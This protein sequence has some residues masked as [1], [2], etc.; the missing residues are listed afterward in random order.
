MG[1][2][3]LYIV[4]A[5]IGN[6][7]DITLRSLRILREE[8]SLVYCEDTR[9]TGKLL[10]A[11][12]ISVKM[13]SLHAHSSNERIAEACAALLRG[14]NLAYLTDA[15]TPGLSDPGSK[16]VAEARSKGISV[17]P[18]PGPSALTALVS[19]AGFPEKNVIF[20]GFLSKKPGR[21]VHEL[22]KLRE[23]EGIIVLYESP[24]RIKKL[25]AD[26]SAV[27][28]ESGLVIGREMSKRFEEFI[29]GTAIELFQN[30]GSITEKGEFALAV[31]NS[32]PVKSAR[33]T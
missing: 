25:L 21:R 26:I 2:G 28:P 1:Y 33:P 4:A 12:N 10:S 9:Q 16:L 22:E 29:T 19:A 6:I 11:H 8:V 3:L 27:F 18:L 32:K 13:R 24:H 23:F 15:G 30:A 20:A 5:P 14:E 17:V 7:E 31:C